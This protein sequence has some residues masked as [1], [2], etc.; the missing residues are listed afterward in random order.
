MCDKMSPEMSFSACLSLTVQK[1]EKKSK[2]ETDW[3]VALAN[4]IME[5][6]GESTN[7]SI[8]VRRKVKDKL[9]LFFFLRDRRR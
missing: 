1:M 8:A 5:C 3:F 6:V 4:T 9:L 2:C 7:R